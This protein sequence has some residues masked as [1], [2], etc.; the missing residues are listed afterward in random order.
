MRQNKYAQTFFLP[1]APLF[2]FNLDWDGKADRGCG[3]DFGGWKRGIGL[4]KVEEGLGST[5]F[6]WGCRIRNWVRQG[7]I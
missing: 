2:F 5:R 3:V 6:G 4:G 7:G 1:Y